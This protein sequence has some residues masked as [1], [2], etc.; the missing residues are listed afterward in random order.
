MITRENSIGRW[1]SMI[2]RHTQMYLDRRLAPYGLG[3]GQVGFLA[4]LYRDAVE[5]QN[6]LAERLCID[7]GTTAEALA[8]LEAAGYITREVSPDDRRV[9]RVRLTPEGEAFRDTFS[10]IL[11]DLSAALASGLDPGERRLLIELLS[12]MAANA[13]AVGRVSDEQAHASA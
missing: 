1:I 8:R 3:A 6:E 12:R 13:E 9:K 5:S 2:H 11:T 10:G 4:A 7:K